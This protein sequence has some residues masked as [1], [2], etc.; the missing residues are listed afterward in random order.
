MLA[1][2]IGY[3]APDWAKAD[4]PYVAAVVRYRMLVLGKSLTEVLFAPHQFSTAYLLDEDPPEDVGSLL[5]LS[6]EALFWELEEFPIVA[7]HFYSPI[8][9]ETP[10]FWANEACRVDAPGALMHYY[11]LPCR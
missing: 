6:E 9:M 5:L 3:E 2:L 11:L 8:Y 10:P 7:T 1:R 4:Q